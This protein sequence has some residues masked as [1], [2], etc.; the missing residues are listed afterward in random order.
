MGVVEGRGGAPRHGQ[1]SEVAGLRRPRLNNFLKEEITNRCAKRLNH[2]G[3]L[4]KRR[5]NAPEPGGGGSA[6]CAMPSPPPLAVTCP[7]ICFKKNN[8]GIIKKLCRTEGDIQSSTHSENA[9]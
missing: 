5:P 9:P 7:D 6:K 3:D 1:S 8:V 4:I 2:D